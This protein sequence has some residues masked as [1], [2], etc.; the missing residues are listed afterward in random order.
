MTVIPNLK[1]WTPPCLALVAGMALALAPVS[2]QDEK[3]MTPPA[4]APSGESTSPD[5]T[6]GI[7]PDAVSSFQVRTYHIRGKKLWEGLLRVLG[8]SGY[9]P[10]EIDEKGMRVKTSFV[11]FQARDYSEAVAEA[12]PR[13]S[14]TYRILQ[15]NQVREGKVSLEGIVS[16]GEGGAVLSLRARILVQGLDQ[17]KRIKIMV[18]RRSSGVIESDF[19]RKLEDTLEL[20]RR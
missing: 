14:A 17:A 3:P 6:A 18:D 5:A 11:D 13:I 1:R 9:P 8:E 12:A 20:E 2:A 15:M 4:G 10:E 19:L 7:H 16:K